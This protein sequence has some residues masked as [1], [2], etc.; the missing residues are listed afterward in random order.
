MEPSTALWLHFDLRRVDGVHTYALCAQLSGKLAVEH[1]RPLH[2]HHANEKSAYS[3]LLQMRHPVLGKM[4]LARVSK[5]HHNRV[6]LLVPPH[7]RID[8]TFTI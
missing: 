7:Q 6:L 5:R 8:A 4:A 1:V 3:E 2:V